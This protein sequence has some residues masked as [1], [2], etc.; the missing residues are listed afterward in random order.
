[1]TCSGQPLAGD[2]VYQTVGG[3]AN[4]G[5]LKGSGIP[6]DARGFIMV[7]AHPDAG[8]H[9]PCQDSQPQRHYNAR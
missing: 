8:T 5:F 6:T 2:V 7:C 3:V 9:L 1:M 4:T